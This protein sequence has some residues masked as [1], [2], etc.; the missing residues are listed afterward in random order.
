LGVKPPK[1]PGVWELEPQFSLRPGKTAVQL[2]NKTP[3]PAAVWELLL[4]RNREMKK[5]NEK[6][7]EIKTDKGKKGWK[8]VPKKH[9]KGKGKAKRGKKVH[10]R[11]R[12]DAKK[13]QRKLKKGEMEV[14]AARSTH[15]FRVWT[16]FFI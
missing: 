13:K 7:K 8:K 5:K 12:M 10:Q 6:E 1:P 15:R 3:Q 16:W 11:N 9:I 4:Q 2:W 14:F